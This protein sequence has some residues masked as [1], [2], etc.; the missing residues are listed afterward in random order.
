MNKTNKSNPITPNVFYEEFCEMTPKDAAAWMAGRIGLDADR[1]RKAE[2]I[3][4]AFRKDK[5]SL[6][7][8]KNS[9]KT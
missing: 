1:Q 2:L 3:L 4:E 5:K 7:T 9:S 8:S 6:D